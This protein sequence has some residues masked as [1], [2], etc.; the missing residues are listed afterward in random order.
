MAN[1]FATKLV[2][3]GID[4][5]SG[6][7][8]DLAPKGAPESLDPTGV[9]NAPAKSNTVRAEYDNFRVRL[10]PKPGREE[11]I[12]G[13]RS[14][15]GLMTPLYSS[16]GVLFPYTPTITANFSVE[17][18]VT[19]PVHSIMDFHSYQRTP[20]PEFTISGQFSVQNKREAVFCLAVIHFF[21]TVTKMYFGQ[22]SFQGQTIPI[23]LS[24]PVLLLN[25]YGEYMINNLPVIVKAYTIELGNNVDYV[26][27][28]LPA[29]QGA[30]GSTTS[31]KP[32]QIQ[33][34]DAERR[35]RASAADLTLNKSKFLPPSTPEQIAD[36]NKLLKEAKDG[37]ITI[38][39]GSITDMTG[40]AYIPSLFT[41]TTTLT[42]QHSPRQVRDFNIE[43]FRR[44][45]LLFERRFGGNNNKVGGW[46]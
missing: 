11:A 27:V 29:P 6:K 21:R 41:I 5:V 30:A 31:N 23:G 39:N 18:S 22:E 13:P 45:D 20:T 37:A 8:S 9:A 3:K 28:S 19:S 42:V 40:T 25:G 38:K 15:S 36:A 46:W 17:Y 14:A 24:P 34:S 4:V 1:S 35:L 16:G 2:N 43:S 26:K 7:I 33:L 10:R 12:Y 32:Q 44:G